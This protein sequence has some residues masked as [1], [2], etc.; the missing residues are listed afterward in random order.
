MPSSI[1]RVAGLSGELSLLAAGCV[2]RDLDELIANQVQIASRWN[3]LLRGVPDKKRMLPMSTG[4]FH[5]YLYAFRTFKLSATCGFSGTP[6]GSITINNRALA[7]THASN[8]ADG[9]TPLH[10]TESNPVNGIMPSDT[11]D[12]VGSYTS[13]ARWPALTYDIPLA[14]NPYAGIAAEAGSFYNDI[15]G[16]NIYDSSDYATGVFGANAS[17]SYYGGDGAS[18]SWYHTANWAH[19]VFFSK[20]E[21]AYYVVPSFYASA[22]HYENDPGTSCSVEIF[23]SPFRLDSAAWHGSGPLN[24]TDGSGRLISTQFDDSAGKF[25]YNNQSIPLSAVFSANGYGEI[26]YSITGRATATVS[27]GAAWD[28]K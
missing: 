7:L 6:T 1:T 21:N 12:G 16:L 18:I 10:L 28:W 3:P 2:I 5:A 22:G 4:E 25:S 20:K 11:S 13:P 15:A 19:W 8:P 24:G 26:R 9:L 23:C 17:Q 27:P 14:T